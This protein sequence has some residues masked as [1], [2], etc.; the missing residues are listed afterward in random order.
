MKKLLSFFFFVFLVAAFF[1]VTASASA[2][3]DDV[4]AA[5]ESAGVD[6]AAET[7]GLSQSAERTL[8]DA[9]SRVDAAEI[10]EELFR[11]FLDASQAIS[12][13]GIAVRLT[14]DEPG[15]RSL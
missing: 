2:I 15:I 1:T 8:S 9:L 10:D 3:P 13:E 6:Y 4:A 5:L 7:A 12:Y 11:L 14:G